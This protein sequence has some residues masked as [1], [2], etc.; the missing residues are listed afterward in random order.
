MRNLFD[1]DGIKFLL[2][3]ALIGFI[4]LGLALLVQPVFMVWVAITMTPVKLWG[5]P[6]LILSLA[7]HG[8][9]YYALSQVKNKSKAKRKRKHDDVFL[10][11]KDQS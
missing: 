3:F 6:G 4:I 9:G 1:L 8:I 10:V 2:A 5:L 11:L 7:L